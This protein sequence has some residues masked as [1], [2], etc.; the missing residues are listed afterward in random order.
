MSIALS[1][2]SSQCIEQVSLQTALL[3]VITAFTNTSH[4]HFKLLQFHPCIVW[5]QQPAPF[6][7]VTI[8]IQKTGWKGVGGDYPSYTFPLFGSPG[9][10]NRSRRKNGGNLN[11][12]IAQ[13]PIRY[14]CRRVPVSKLHIRIKPKIKMA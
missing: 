14:Y 6:F 7:E 11:P 10:M 12:G 3:L 5:F 13:R 2:E 8:K 9:S 1:T 4:W